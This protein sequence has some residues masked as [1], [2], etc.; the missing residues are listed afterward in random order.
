MLI[1][2]NNGS[3][4]VK[5]VKI[6]ESLYHVL[7]L[8]DAEVVLTMPI[9]YELMRVIKDVVKQQNMITKWILNIIQNQWDKMI[10]QPLH[11]ADLLK[12]VHIVYTQLDPEAVEIANFGNE[13]EKKS[14]DEQAAIAARSKIQ[15]DRGVIVSSSSN[16]QNTSDGNSGKKDDGDDED[17]GGGWDSS[18]GGWDAGATGW[19]ASV[20]S[21]DA[22][23]DNFDQN[24]GR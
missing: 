18:A 10:N 20:A 13:D 22:Y 17:E 12:A 24:R 8:V 6:Y 5:A 11:A 15:L 7:R 14:F 9:L 4:F 23:A 2:T 3:A 16:D 1:V 21:W 19:N